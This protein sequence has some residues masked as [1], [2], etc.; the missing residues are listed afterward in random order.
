MRPIVTALLNSS[1][2]Y[3]KNALTDFITG[4][5]GVVVKS[6]G[7]QMFEH[8]ATTE[9]TNDMPPKT[10]ANINLARTLTMLVGFIPNQDI[11]LSQFRKFGQ[12]FLILHKLAE[13]NF[14]VRQFL[15]TN[16]VINMVFD[17]YMMLDS[18]KATQF[19]KSLSP[20][21]SLFADLI[22]HLKA[23]LNSL[24]DDNQS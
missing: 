2:Q 3:V 1:D 7:I 19:E 12:V 16:N 15:L 4:V 13:Q 23:A 20:L 5:F 11:N 10:I 9:I 18:S 6:F 24:K 8:A 22:L 14:C 17:L 21:L